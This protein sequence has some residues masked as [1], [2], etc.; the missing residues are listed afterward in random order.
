MGGGLMK[1][2][3]KSVSILLI[4]TMIASLFTIIPFEASA[5]SGVQYIERSWDDAN[6]AVVDTE[7]TCTSYT[8]LANRSSDTLYSG[9]YVVDRDMTVNGRLRVSGTVNLILCDH[10]TPSRPQ[11]D[12]A[13]AIRRD[14]L[15]KV[16]RPHPLPKWLIRYAP[17]CISASRFGR[18]PHRR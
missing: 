17:G 6:K 4:M 1:F 2:I 11:L 18:K 9:W 13:Y 7:K 14:N 16:V 5:A 12:L 15:Y 8:L 10:K 3:K